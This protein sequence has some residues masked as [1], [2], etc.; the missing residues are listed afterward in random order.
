MIKNLV[1]WAAVMLL[2][3]PMV[4]AQDEALQARAIQIAAE[5]EPFEDWLDQ[6]PGWNGYAA[7][8]NAEQ[9]V[10]KVDFNM[11]DEWL[12]GAW[13]NIETGELSNVFVPRPYPAD[14]YAETQ[15]RIQK[16]V[17]ED[18]EVRALMA[19]GTGWDVS[20]EFDRF[21]QSWKT[22]IR[23]GDEVFL[24]EAGINEYGFNI[25][26]VRV[27]EVFEVFNRYQDTN[28][29]VVDQLF[30]HDGL[31]MVLEAMPDNKLYTAYWYGSTWSAEFVSDGRLIFHALID[32]E[33]GDFPYIACTLKANGDV[34]MRVGPGTH[35][36]AVDLLPSRHAAVA[37]GQASDPDGATWWRLTNG[38]WVHSSVVN[39]IMGDC[40]AQNVPQI[41]P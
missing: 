19:G 9:T 24:V 17:M 41:N 3:I 25:N 16:L 4:T 18:A 11:P 32:V 27:G 28:A 29:R 34:N 30:S 35:H 26:Q 31:W 1:I 14:Q 8:T 37:S 33:N 2:G 6:H 36:E 15:A 10:W 40:T 22:H 21:S 20:T 23:S 39:V 7:P 38:L 12:G 5:S 13:V